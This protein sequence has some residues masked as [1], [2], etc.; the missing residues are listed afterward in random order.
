M[1]PKG[2]C[3]KV[4]IPSL[5]LLRG[6]VNFPRLVLVASPPVIGSIPLKGMRPQPL[7]PHLHL[8]H[9]EGILLHCL[10]AALPQAPKQ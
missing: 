10:L 2:P 3:V 4:L 5:A 1:S 8:N 6:G 9:E 7:P